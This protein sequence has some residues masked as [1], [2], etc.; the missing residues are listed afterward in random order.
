MLILRNIIINKSLSLQKYYVLRNFG[1]FIKNLLR[2]FK[3]YVI[4]WICSLFLFLLFLFNRV[5]LSM[6]KSSMGIMFW[7]FLLSHFLRRRQKLIL[8][9][10]LIMIQNCLITGVIPEL[11]PLVDVHA[12]RQK[13]FCYFSISNFT[14]IMQCVES[15][16]WLN[17]RIG[18]CV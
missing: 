15:I 18:S 11:I 10:M 2:N 3:F 13:H 6:D 1:W 17:I 16:L 5:L 12:I 9:H 4:T 14:G 8:Q 7:P